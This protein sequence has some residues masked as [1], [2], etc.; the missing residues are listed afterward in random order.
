MRRPYAAFIA[1]G[2]VFMGLAVSS[3]NNAFYGVAVAFFIIAFVN[4]R[5]L[6]NQ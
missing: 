1:L 3:H 4:W 2:A 6:R 5:R